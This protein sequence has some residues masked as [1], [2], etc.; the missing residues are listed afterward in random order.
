MTNTTT[1]QIDIETWQQLNAQKQPG[2][3]F[4]DVIRDLLNQ[5]VAYGND[6]ERIE[7]DGKIATLIWEWEPGRSAE[8]REERREVGFEALKWLREQEVATRSDFI[9]ALYREYNPANVKKRGWWRNSVRP[10]LNIARERGIVQ[11]EE[12]S[13]EWQW[14]G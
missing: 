7:A 8:E 4:D 3:S 5:N 10:I 9:D 12:G 6:R 14:I 1:I 11:F 2:D 13:K